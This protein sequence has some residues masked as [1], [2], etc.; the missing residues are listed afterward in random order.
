[1]VVKVHVPGACLV[2]L[3][4]SVGSG[5]TMINVLGASNTGAIAITQAIADTLDSGIKNALNAGTYKTSLA[6][7]TILEAVGVRDIS[8]PD[9]PEFLGAAASVPGTGTGDDLPRQ[10]ALVAS[11][12]T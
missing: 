11:L 10:A 4:W 7:S 1:M 12:R 2:R 5:G 8:N 9:L 6:P 3:I